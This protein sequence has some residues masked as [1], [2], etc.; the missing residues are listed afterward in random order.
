MEIS[1]TRLNLGAASAVKL[2]IIISP[3][4]KD[5]NVFPAHDSDDTPQGNPPTAGFTKA[6]RDWT[7]FEVTDFQEDV[8][9]TTT[10]TEG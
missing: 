8:D 4:F 9:E 6:D 3:P 7:T 1:V 2:T 5:P 10:Y